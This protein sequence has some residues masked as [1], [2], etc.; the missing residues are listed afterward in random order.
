MWCIKGAVL[1]DKLHEIM[2]LSDRSYV[3]SSTGCNFVYHF[4]KLFCAE[5]FKIL[6]IAILH[7][8]VTNLKLSDKYGFYL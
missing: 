1:R 6:V 8:A 2:I 5:M 4:Y 3:Y 7:Q